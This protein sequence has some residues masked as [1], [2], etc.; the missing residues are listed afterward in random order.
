MIL[1]KM[2]QIYHSGI[3]P[4]VC[5][6]IDDHKLFLDSGQMKQTDRMMLQCR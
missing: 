2:D 6:M 1:M 3:A 5:K 4:V